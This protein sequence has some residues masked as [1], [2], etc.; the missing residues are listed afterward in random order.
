MNT[1]TTLAPV[2]TRLVFKIYAIVS[3]VAG[4][5]LY[6]SG[7]V[8][9]RVPITGLPRFSDHM[10]A[11]LA[12][13]V[14]VGAGFLAIAMSRVADEDDRRRALGWWACAHGVVF[15]GVTLQLLVFT[16]IARLDWGVVVLVAWLFGVCFL[17][18]DL[19]MTA[20][21]IPFGGLGL[22]AS[23]SV[24]G[25]LRRP[26]AQR[27]RSTYE[28]KI[29]EAAGQEERNRLARELHDSIKQQIFVM[30]T[31]AATAQ[32]RFASDPAGAS[33][34]I[35]QVR[36]SAR[37]AMAEMEAMLDQL[38]ASPLE[39]VGLVEALKKQC[40]ALRLRTGAEVKFTVGELPPNEA[41][42]VGAQQALFR[43]AQEAFA[44]VSR[45]ARAR[46][47]T[48]SLD[49]TP[50]SLELRI[51][52]DGVGFDTTQPGS[53]MGLGNMR[54][55]VAGLGGTLVLTSVPGR[56]TLVRASVPHATTQAVSLDLHHRRTLLWGS[57]VLASVV[58]TLWMATQGDRYMT[59]VFVVN[60]LVLAVEFGRVA[61]DYFRARKARA[62]SPSG[63]VII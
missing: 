63:R 2:N 57:A 41:L 50:L 32:A 16:D 23:P 11:R 14:M 55:R 24:L 62:Q 45:H 53:G 42:P 48:V 26:A 40:E 34:A 58:F 12:G 22:R 13:A 18:G 1:D 6:G 56:G 5:F 19:W 30:H 44:N 15:A 7:G 31:A 61:F 29:R 52:D 27:L 28:E 33:A 8:A 49:S 60:V 35:E 36:N 37:D 3:L 9:F 51:D 46:H 10:A 4:A 54:G 25:E 39:N 47:V 43:V 20:D 38:R 59:A 17:F 21:G